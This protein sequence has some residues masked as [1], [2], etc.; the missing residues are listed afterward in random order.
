MPDEIPEG[1]TPFTVTI[2][3]HDQ[4]VDVIRPGDRMEITG[5]FRWYIVPKNS[6]SSFCPFS[7]SEHFGHRAV[8]RRVNPKHR[9]VSSVY[10]TYIDAIH[11]RDWSDISS[12]MWYTVIRTT[13][14]NSNAGDAHST[15]VIGEDMITY[16]SSSQV[17]AFEEFANQGNVYEKLTAAFAP[18][19]WEMGECAIGY[20]AACQWSKFY[21][22]T[23]WRKVFSACCLGER[24]KMQW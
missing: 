20:V 18:S 5:I 15:A 24:C 3:I 16:F 23:M 13:L 19:I 11:F 8:P 1:E 9:T 6:P 10:K 12:I 17:E 2:F 22:Q 21:N 7:L 4:Q 14:N